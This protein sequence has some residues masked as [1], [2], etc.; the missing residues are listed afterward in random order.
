MMNSKHTPGPWGWWNR[1][2]VQSNPDGTI[3]LNAKMI[4]KEAPD[5]FNEADSALVAAA[6]EMLEWLQEAVEHAEKFIDDDDPE[7]TVPGFYWSAKAAIAKAT[8]GA[9]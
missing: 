3:P 6:P 2:L 1:F 5:F 4:M 9:E 8:G 7:G